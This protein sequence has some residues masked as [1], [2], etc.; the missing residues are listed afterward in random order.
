MSKSKLTFTQRLQVRENRQGPNNPTGPP[1][2]E[3]VTRVGTCVETGVVRSPLRGSRITCC[4]DR[5]HRKEKGAAEG[6]TSV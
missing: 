6:R 3:T 2:F 5:I 1:S 4:S